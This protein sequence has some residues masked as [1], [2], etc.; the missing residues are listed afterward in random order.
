MD[1]SFRKQGETAWRKGMPLARLQNERI[2]QRNVFDLVSPNMF[3]GSI[4][5]LE[6]DTAYEARFVMTDPDGA[7]PAANATKTVTVRTRPEPKPAADGK[8]YHVYPTKWKGPKT[9]PAFEGIMCAYNYY[10]G[11]GDTA[12]GGRPRVKPGDVILVHAGTYAYHYEFYANQ[13]TVNATTTFEGT[14]Y[15]TGKGTPE[16][17]IVIKAAGDGEVIL[18][19]RGNFNLFNVKA[20]DYNYFE[21]ITFRNTSIAIWAGT[22]FIAGVER[23]DREALPLRGRRHGHLH[24]LRR[25]ERLLHRRQRV[26]RDATIRST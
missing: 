11:A 16:R 12:P 22:Q 21:G 10:C 18:D 6:P 9:E 5:D 14:Y 3:A 1:V 13:T 24:E 17:P 23:T 15:L 26:P 2:Y 19:G 8:V 7:G 4:L 20:A 25:L